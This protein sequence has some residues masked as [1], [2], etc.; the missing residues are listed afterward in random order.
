M[1]EIELFGALAV[2]LMA[3][4]YALEARSPVFTLLFACGCVA[5]S[6]YAALI[7]S[8]PFATVEFLWAGVAVRRFLARKSPL[9]S[10]LNPA[11]RA[12]SYARSKIWKLG[13][14]KLSGDAPEA[15]ARP[16]GRPHTSRGPAGESPI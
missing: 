9:D 15:R 4:C 5:S 1:N 3:G 7:G 2:S 13:A 10:I 16:C 11:R 8:W 14:S 6:A 12:Y